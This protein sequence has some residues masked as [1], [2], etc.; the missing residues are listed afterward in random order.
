M[1]APSGTPIVAVAAGT[2]SDA[3]WL[4]GGAGYGVILDHGVGW[5]TKYFHMLARPLPVEV[6]DE[7]S[8]GS[9]IGWVG[10]TGNSARPHLHFEVEVG[11]KEID[12]LLGFSYFSVGGPLIVGDATDIA[13]LDHFDD[14]VDSGPR[15][16]LGVAAES[17]AEPTH[18]GFV[19][20]EEDLA[21]LVDLVTDRTP[22]TGALALIDEARETASSAIDE[23]REMLLKAGGL[24]FLGFAVLALGRGVVRSSRVRLR[25]AA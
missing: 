5:Q 13:S 25:G 12:P 11:G 1:N 17:S 6:G 23:E 18:P 9:V 4:T 14:A 20:L 16:L 24:V 22:A 2:V 15:E 7:V 19:D 3:G 21:D 10:N 8:I